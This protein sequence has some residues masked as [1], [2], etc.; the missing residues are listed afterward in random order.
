MFADLCSGRMWSAELAGT[1]L[2]AVRPLG[3][4]APYPVSFGQD[5]RGRLYVVDFGGRVFRL[6]A[7]AR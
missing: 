2:I 1:E 4:T 7:S 6:T 3:L 5:A